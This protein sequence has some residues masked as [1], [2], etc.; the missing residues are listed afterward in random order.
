MTEI[1]ASKSSPQKYERKV[2]TELFTREERSE[3]IYIKSGT[4]NQKRVVTWSLWSTHK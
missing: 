2:A 4:N 1:R 3:E